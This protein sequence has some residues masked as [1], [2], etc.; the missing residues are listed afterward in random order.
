MRQIEYVGKILKELNS[1]HCDDWAEWHLQGGIVV[2]ARPPLRA[3]VPPSTPALAG[4][5]V[6]YDDGTE[7]W[8][9][10]KVMPEVV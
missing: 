8:S 4:W 10:V 7:A 5:Y 9:P 3:Q 1:A 6:L 2:A